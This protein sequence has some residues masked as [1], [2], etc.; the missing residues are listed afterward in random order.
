MTVYSLLRNFDDPAIPSLAAAYPRFLLS[1]RFLSATGPMWFAVAL[2]IFCIVYAAVRSLRGSASAA[3][4]PLPNDRHVIGLILVMGTCSFLVRIVQPIGATVLNMQ[5][6][7]FSQYILLF[8]VGI[9]AYRGNWLVHIPRA[10]GRRWRRLTLTAGMVAWFALI[11]TSGA[12]QGKTKDLLGGFHWQSAA[13]C[14]WEAF[15]CMG[16]CLG[17][18]VLFRDLYNSQGRFSQWM[19]RNSFTAY[20]FHPPLLIAVTLMLKQWPAPLLVKFVV[21]SLIAVPVTF[22]VSGVLRPN[23]PGLRR[24][25]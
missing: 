10:F 4:P 1:G 23:I 3:L 9:L 12:L 8:T 2:L 21:A 11:A 25:L 13:F 15:F 20:F 17:L 18:T 19:S 16:M 14:F 22:I 7:Y 24:W 5:L 6:C